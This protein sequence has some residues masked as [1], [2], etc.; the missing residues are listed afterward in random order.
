MFSAY[1]V[2]YFKITRGKDE[3]RGERRQENGQ[4]W[5]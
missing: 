1:N 2:Q 4:G 3:D 5:I